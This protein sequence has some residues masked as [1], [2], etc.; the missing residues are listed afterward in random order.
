[1][2]YECEPALD[3]AKSSEIAQHCFDL[4]REERQQIERHEHDE[5]FSK[6]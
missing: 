2:S 5:S 6:I 1:M 3:D 4:R